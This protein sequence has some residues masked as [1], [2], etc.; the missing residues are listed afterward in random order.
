LLFVARRSD[1]GLWHKD[2]RILPWLCVLPWAVARGTSV[3]V[4]AWIVGVAF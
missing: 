4:G 1:D 3:K 2:G